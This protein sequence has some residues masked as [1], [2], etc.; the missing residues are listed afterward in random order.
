[1]KSIAIRA[2]LLRIQNKDHKLDDLI[3]AAIRETNVSESVLSALDQRIVREYLAWRDL[4]P[5]LEKFH[6]PTLFN[7]LY[8]QMKPGVFEAAEL[9]KMGYGRKIFEDQLCKELYATATGKVGLYGYIF[10]ALKQCGGPQ[11]LEMMEVIK[12]E[13]HPVIQTNRIVADAIRENYSE[14]NALSVAAVHQ[15]IV[16]KFLSDFVPQLYS[17][18][19]ALRR[20]GIELPDKDSEAES[21]TTPTSPGRSRRVKHYVFKA[22]D[23]LPDHPAEALN[24]IRKAA[25]AICKDVIDNAFQH[26]PGANN[27]PASAF[28]SLEDMINRMRRDGLIPSSIETCLVSLKSFGNYASHDQDED[29]QSISVEMAESTFGHLKTVVEWYASLNLQLEQKDE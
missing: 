11:S 27:K 4:Q 24:N 19:Q 2:W 12:Q 15:L 8:E 6:R 21:N 28:N 13:L 26:S 10:D 7:A 17:A 16:N 9:F 20:K 1:M 14:E 23:L 22:K 5:Y 29:P 25:E 18:I 3:N